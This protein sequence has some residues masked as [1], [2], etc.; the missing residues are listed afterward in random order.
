MDSLGAEWERRIQRNLSE[1]EV[2]VLRC[3][4]PETLDLLKSSHAQP[5][6]THVACGVFDLPEYPNHLYPF[7]LSYRPNREAPPQSSLRN[8]VQEL[9][10]RRWLHAYWALFDV[11][12]AVKAATLKRNADGTQ[13]TQSEESSATADETLSIVFGFQFP[14]SSTRRNIAVKSLSDSLLTSYGEITDVDGQLV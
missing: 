11:V 8:I 10:G 7:T 4:L 3:L 14:S 2:F 13:T 1:L 6:V 9:E 5:S 12:W